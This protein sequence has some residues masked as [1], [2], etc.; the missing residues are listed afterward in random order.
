VAARARQHAHALPSIPANSQRRPRTPLHAAEALRPPACDA[1]SLQRAV[2]CARSA[3]L[4][5]WLSPRLSLA[6]S[7]S[8]SLS[9]SLSL[10]LSLAL[11]L[12]LVLSLSLSLARARALFRALSLALSLALSRSLARSLSLSLALSYSASRRARHVSPRSL[13]LSHSHACAVVVLSW[14]LAGGQLPLLLTRAKPQT[15]NPKPETLN[16]KP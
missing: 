14:L 4:A 13:M 11:S 16:P 6:R 1:A 5:P 10:A 7:R 3:S 2:A 15:L 9:L 12:S 8:L